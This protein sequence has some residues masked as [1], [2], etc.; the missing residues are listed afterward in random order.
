M[1]L[2]FLYLAFAAVLRLLA[3]GR[4]DPF[5][6]EVE[7]LALRHELEVLLLPTVPAA[8]AACRSCLSRCARAA[9]AA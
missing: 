7:L 5:A 2:S 4:R 9:A 1:L 3:A 6:R 8:A